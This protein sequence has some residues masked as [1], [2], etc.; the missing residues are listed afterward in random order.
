M[1]ACTWLGATVL[2]TTP[3]IIWVICPPITG[4]S[5]TCWMEVFLKSPL[6]ELCMKSDIGKVL[7]MSTP[8]VT[9]LP[10]MVS[11]KMPCVRLR[12]CSHKSIMRPH[13]GSAHITL[14]GT[15]YAAA[16]S[17]PNCCKPHMMASLP[18]PS[19]R[20]KISTTSS[21]STNLHGK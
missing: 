16:L 5:R 17:S 12:S 14:S 20:V 10:C 9:Q 1:F 13:N 6:W 19:R 2:N 21:M 4:S 11:R 15:I 7:L 18:S 3:I 8:L